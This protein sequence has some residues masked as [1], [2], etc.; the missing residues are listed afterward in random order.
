MH[1]SAVDFLY[2]NIGRGH[3]FYL[4]GLREC[5]ARETVGSVLDVLDVCRGPWRWPWG[6]ARV[7]YEQGSSLGGRTPLYSRLRARLDFSR[8]GPALRLIGRPLVRAFADTGRAVVLSHPR[9]WMARRL[10]ES[11]SA[12]IQN[13][14][15]RG[16]GQ[17]ILPFTVYTVANV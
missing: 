15:E 1:T 4:D 5:L 17:D 14:Q 8:P 10:C 13:R 3:P 9:D 12:A 6:L 2:V 16:R 11:M 7:L